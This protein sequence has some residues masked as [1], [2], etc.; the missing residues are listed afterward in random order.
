M[1]VECH[2]VACVCVLTEWQSQSKKNKKNW[3]LGFFFSKLGKKHLNS[4]WNGV[5][6]RLL[7]TQIKNPWTLYGI[8]TPFNPFANRA[9]WSGCTLFSYGNVI[10]YDPTLVD[11]TSNFFVLCNVQTWK[12]N[13]IIIHSGWS[14]AWIFMK[15]SHILKFTY[16]MCLY[17]YLVGIEAYILAQAYICIPTLHQ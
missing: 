6:F 1:V 2:H 13:Y 4:I 17:S 5:K 8:E 9:G 3:R 14:L 7:S 12:F 16:S 11:L 10:R 15:E